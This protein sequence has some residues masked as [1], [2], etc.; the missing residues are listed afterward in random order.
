V[1]L[2]DGKTVELRWKKDAEGIWIEL[3]HGVFGYDISGHA[4]DEGRTVYTVSQR[5]A[6][7]AW[8]GLSLMRAGEE[9]AAAGAAAG[10]KK[11]VR[12]RAQMPGKI[13]SISAKPG[14]VVEKEQPLLVMEAMKME[15]VIR[16]PQAGKI[17]QVKVT[18]GQA[19]ETGADLCVI[20]PV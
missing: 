6:P 16:A 18:A 3:P 17:G 19:V 11:G 14:D 7:G 4:D 8:S 12:V 5:Q 15:N 9:S 1:Q 13:I 10:P 2:S 20:D